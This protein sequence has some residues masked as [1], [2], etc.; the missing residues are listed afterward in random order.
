MSL[1][2]GGPTALS[3]VS[4]GIE[5]ERLPAAGPGRVPVAP[6]AGC[7]ELAGVEAGERVLEVANLVVFGSAWVDAHKREPVARGAVERRQHLVVGDEEVLSAGD[8][9]LDLDA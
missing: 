9:G 1:R 2:F 8:A 5:L 3:F 4:V 7:G 6:V